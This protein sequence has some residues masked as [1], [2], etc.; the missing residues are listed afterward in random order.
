MI[1]IGDIVINVLTTW[2]SGFIKYNSDKWEYADRQTNLDRR[3][4]LL[5]IGC[6]D[7]SENYRDINL[8]GDI[9]EENDVYLIR[10]DNGYVVYHPNQFKSINKPPEKNNLT[11]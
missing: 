10:W 5:S 8:R 9:N 6:T 7:C 1:K 11:L 2:C 4:F 3:T